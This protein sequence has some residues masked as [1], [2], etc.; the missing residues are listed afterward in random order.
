MTAQTNTVTIKGV[1]YDIVK[2]SDIIEADG[3]TGKKYWQGHVLWNTE[4]GEFFTTTSSWKETKTGI[5]KINWAVPNFAAPKN[6]GRANATTN[7]D[8]A[9]F[10]FDSMVAVEKRKRE[11]SRPQPMLAQKFSERSHKITYPAIVQPKLDGM[12]FMTDGTVG[13]SRG[14][15][16]Q[17]LEVT[18]HI[19]PFDTRGCVLD[20]EL[21][22]NWRAPVQLVMSAAKK[23]QPGLSEKLIYVVYDIVIPDAPDTPYY[24]RLVHLTDIVKRINKASVQIIECHIVKTQDEFL[25]RHAAYSNAGYEGSILRNGVGTYADGKR[26]DDLLKHKDWIDEE[27]EIVDI[28]EA[29]SGS[30]AG[31]GKFVCRAKNGNPFESTAMGSEEYR[32]NLLENKDKYVGRWAVVKYREL[33]PDGI[34][35]HSNVREVR[36]TKTGGY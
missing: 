21:L 12:R 17:L 34:P 5:S 6:I 27:F 2:S 36:E 15:K 9:F 4:T 7:E 31:I 24:D 30:S 19:L 26:S 16:D 3:K 32:R 10:E 20:G 25:A 8:Q 28:I 23:Y 13:W 11:T 14:N 33:T 1:E 35:F 29:G 18:Q 22:L